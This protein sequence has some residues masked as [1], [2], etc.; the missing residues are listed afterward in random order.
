MDPLSRIREN[1]S[2]SAQLKLDAAD[3][4][5]PSIARGGET[6]EQVLASGGK[7]LSCG[8]G[9]SAADAQ[10]F[11]AELINRFQIER[12]ALA[13]IALTTDTSILTSIGNDYDFNLVFSKQIHALGKKHDIAWGISTSG[14]SCAIS[15]ERRRCGSAA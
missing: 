11:A 8:N 13:A 15:S 9:G 10:H 2:Q 7:I 12:P 3:Q 5:A 4:M 6:L 1:F 14:N